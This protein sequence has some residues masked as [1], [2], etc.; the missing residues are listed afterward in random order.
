VNLQN[1]HELR[2][3][4][5]KLEMLEATYQA[6]QEDTGA[7]PHIRELELHSIRRLIN[8]LKEEIARFESRTAVR[9][10]E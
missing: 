6:A 9:S 3:T 2:V 10:R 8:Q 4:R 7:D 1:E 5:K